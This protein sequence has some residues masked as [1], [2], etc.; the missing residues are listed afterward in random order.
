MHVGFYVGKLDAQIGGGFTYIETFL[1]IIENLETHHTF[2]VFHLGESPQSPYKK[3]RF[4]RLDSAPFAGSFFYKLGGWLSYTHQKIMRFF[5]LGQSFVG[6]IGKSPLQKKL[7][8]ERVAF[9]WFI[10]PAPQL[11]EVPYAL[12]IW[13]LQHRYQPYFPEVGNVSEWYYR[14]SYYRDFV[15]R[16]AVII[17]SHDVFRTEIMQHYGLPAFRIQNMPHPTPHFAAQY[18]ENFEKK[19]LKTAVSSPYIF[20]PAQY[21][22]HKNH[23]VI[24]E[25][26]YILKTQGISIN[27]VFV[28]SDKGNKAFIQQKINELGLQNNVQLLGFIEREELIALYQNALALVFASFFGPEN[29]PPLE[30]M[31]FKCPVICADFEGAEAQLA[32]S[33]C[34]FEKTNENDLANKITLFLNDDDL[35]EKYIQKGIEQAQKYTG[36]ALAPN[37]LTLLNDFEKIR[38]N[39]K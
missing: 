2:V 18:L 8:S 31:C 20:Y 14:E 12:T 22:S 6:K 28:G 36:A 29:L 33:V 24:L 9:F 21:W 1:N 23:I 5:Q 32:D 15:P 11:I 10:Y 38:R 17:S 4:R 37:I 39:W 30:A 35:R 34:Y 26:L 27:A 13:D 19:E 16:A 25:S 7:D 3:I